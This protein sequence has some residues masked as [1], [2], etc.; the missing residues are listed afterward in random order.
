VTPRLLLLAA[1]TQQQSVLEGLYLGAHGSL[2]E[3]L[4][5]LGGL[6]EG[7]HLAQ[8][9]LGVAV[10]H[11]ARRRRRGGGG[12]GSGNSAVNEWQCYKNIER[13]LQMLVN[14]ATTGAE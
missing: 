11:S 12:V 4:L 14:L 3:V 1:R 8:T 7:L 5:A 13:K 6:Q 2:A 9:V 10:T